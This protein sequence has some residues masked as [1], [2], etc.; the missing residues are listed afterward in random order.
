MATMVHVMSLKGCKY[1]VNRKEVQ[2]YCDVVKPDNLLTEVEKIAL[3]EFMKN[4]TKLRIQSSIT[5]R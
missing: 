2:A 3:K 1:L 4:S 5:S